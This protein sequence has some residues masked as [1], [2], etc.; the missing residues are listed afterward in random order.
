MRITVD[1]EDNKLNAILK[2]T[3]QT[4]KSPAIAAAL[5]EY[6]EQK[7]RQALLEKVFAGKT[8][9]AASNEKIEALARLEE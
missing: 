2:W 3:R 7:R 4:K 1:I 8:D 9:Y 6:L 5:N